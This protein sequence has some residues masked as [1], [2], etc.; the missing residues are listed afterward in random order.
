[1]SKI[2]VISQKGR[3][4]GTWIPPHNARSGVPI[5]VPV[6]GPD[7]TLHEIDIEDPESFVRR[8]ALPELHKLVRQRLGL[9]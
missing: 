8:K 4:V 1:M 2:S 6:A 7:Q 5:S 3:L 9:K